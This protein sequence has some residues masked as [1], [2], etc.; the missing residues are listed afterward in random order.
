[1]WKFYSKDGTSQ[2]MQWDG[3]TTFTD[4][5]TALSGIRIYTHSGNWTNAGTWYLY[6][7]KS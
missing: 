4:N 2:Y 7:L 1:M 3:S 5:T 6:G